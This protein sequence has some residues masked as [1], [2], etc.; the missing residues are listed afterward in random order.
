MILAA[1]PP[2][3]PGSSVYPLGIHGPHHWSPQD[4]QE[5]VQETIRSLTALRGWC[6]WCSFCIPWARKDKNQHGFG[7][8]VLQWW[9][10]F[11]KKDRSGTLS[12]LKVVYVLGVTTCYSYH[13][14][15]L[16][17]CPKYGWWTHCG[18][19]CIKKDHY[20]HYST[21]DFQWFPM[22][23][24]QSLMKSQNPMVQSLVTDPRWIYN[25]NIIMTIIRYI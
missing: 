8:F 9:I 6:G 19:K 4:C 14:C 3:I 16:A 17:L 25:N 24:T 2:S 21:L 13:S 7:R 1:V 22:I 15:C 10:L 23:S 18:S 11:N 12:T 20:N 5:N